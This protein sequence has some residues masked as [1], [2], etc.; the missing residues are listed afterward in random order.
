MGVI[1]T[2]PSYHAQVWEYP[3]RDVTILSIYTDYS[4]QI[5]FLFEMTP[6]IM[7]DTIMFQVNAIKEYKEYKDTMQ[8]L[9]T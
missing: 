5:A 9:Y 4:I 7:R 3:T 2:E 8:S 1:T 6:F